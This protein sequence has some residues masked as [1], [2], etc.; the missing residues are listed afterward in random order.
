MLNPNGAQGSG[1][2]L[3][4]RAAAGGIHKFHSLFIHFNP[5]THAPLEAGVLGLALGEQKG[6]RGG[7]DDDES[8][9]LITFVCLYDVCRVKLSLCCD[10]ITQLTHSVHRSTF[11]KGFGLW[12]LSD[13]S[14]FLWVSQANRYHQGSL[15]T[16]G[17]KD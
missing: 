7:V 5:I 2:T 17:G 12:A 3:N 10:I 11:L 1:V 14:L 6:E 15:G 8:Q 4:A 16:S 9:K 13:T